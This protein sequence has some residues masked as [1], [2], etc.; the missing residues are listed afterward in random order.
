MADET[1]SGVPAG[2]AEPAEAE[3]PLAADRR[4]LVIGGVSMVVLILIGVVS[5]QLFARGGCTS[6]LSPGPAAAVATDVAPEAVVDEHL[7]PVDGDR[8][9]D[10]VEQVAGARV[11]AAIPVGEANRVAPLDGGLLTAGRTVTSLDDQLTP[12]ATVTTDDVV[13]GDGPAVHAVT[14]PDE[15]SGQTDAFV[16]LRG[17]DLDVGTCIDT[18][19]VGAPFAFHLDAGGGQL[20]LIRA[21]E[22]GQ[23]PH[24]DLRGPDGRSVW[25]ADLDLPGGPPG[26]M[27][28]RLTGRLGPDTVVAARRVSPQEEGAA[29]A[30]FAV[31][32]DD[33]SPRFTVDGDTLAAAAGLDPA[34]PI[35]WQV[36][37]VGPTTALVHGRPDRLDAEPTGVGQPR[38]D[39]SLVLLDLRD[40]Q[41]LTARTDVGPVTA[42]AADRHATDVPDRYILATGRSDGGSDELAFLDAEGEHTSLGSL[43]AQP[44]F[45]W[46]DGT[47][48][49]AARDSL[50]RLGPQDATPAVHVLVG[51]RFADV[52]LTED[53]RVATLVTPRDGD[54]AVLLVT[55]PVDDLATGG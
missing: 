33:G 1:T 46:L 50:S 53:G 16:P 10:I 55:E 4:T 44:R 3:D 11:V 12:V 54:E 34:D 5:A 27:A 21:D 24:L 31:S 18:A 8:A 25:E 32:R 39:G 45:A 51:G 48:L 7:H 29:P 9:V 43:L 38:E 47:V 26:T 28:E 17:T 49:V 15:R 37:A 20:L 35:R 22:E 6:I 30:V 2:P 41:P 19:V 13:V 23:G 36:A 40:G 52:T 42:A 14:I